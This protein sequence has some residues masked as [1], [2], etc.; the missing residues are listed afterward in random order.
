MMDIG[1][2]MLD[3]TASRR[4]GS[5]FLAFYLTAMF[6]YHFMV[7]RVNRHLATGEKFPHSMSFGQRE[8]LR[9]LYKALYPR[10]P[11]YQF[12]MT[13]AFLLF[14]LALAFAGLRVW[15]CARDPYHL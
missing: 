12:T 13:C 3:S 14:I 10:S 11:L 5:A 2:N 7:Y 15:A 9:D 8:R 1:N 6:L 4:F